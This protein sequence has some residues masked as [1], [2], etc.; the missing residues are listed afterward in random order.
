LGKLK[1]YTFKADPR[2]IQ[3]LDQIAREL[4]TSRGALIRAGIANVITAY[5][6]RKEPRKLRVLEL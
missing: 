1:T 2:E 6:N 3:M 4:N 5:L